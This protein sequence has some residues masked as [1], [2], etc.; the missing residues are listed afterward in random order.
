MNPVPRV[1][2]EGARK[3]T[4]RSAQAV[5]R[6]AAHAMTFAQAEGDG[7]RANM[8]EPPWRQEVTCSAIIFLYI[9]IAA[10]ALAVSWPHVSTSFT[11]Y[12]DDGLFSHLHNRV[13]RLTRGSTL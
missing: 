9:C 2:P 1:D 11:Q 13:T 6:K 10:L 12:P 4:K 7:A 3:I 8:G 5:S